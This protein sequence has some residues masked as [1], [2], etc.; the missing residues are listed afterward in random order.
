MGGAH[1]NHNIS[2]M[3]MTSQEIKHFISQMPDSPT[4][5]KLADEIKVVIISFQNCPPGISSA[6]IIGVCHQTSNEVSSLTD[7]IDA[8]LEVSSLE[9]ESKVF[10]TNFAVDCV[11]AES[12][13][14]MTT[15]CKFFDGK[16]RFCCSVDNKHNAK[17][18]RYQLIDGSCVA[19]VGNYVIGY[20]LLQLSGVVK[21][22]WRVCDFASD[23]LAACIDLGRNWQWDLNM[24]MQ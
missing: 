7:V 21:D 3:N 15:V 18:D 11:S 2:K 10:F 8:A 6:K 4:P 13:D 9:I 20:E 1:P 12:Q 23:R 22:L 19:T 17:S 5:V 24:G 16:A 14:V